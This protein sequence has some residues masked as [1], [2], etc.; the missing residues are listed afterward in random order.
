MLPGSAPEEEGDEEGASSRRPE[1]VGCRAAA[2]A[3]LDGAGPGRQVRVRAP[4]QRADGRRRRGRRAEAMRGAA[5]ARRTIGRSSGGGGFG[6]SG[7]P[8]GVGGQRRQ[9]RRECQP[10]RRAYP[11][12]CATLLAASRGRCHRWLAHA[13]RPNDASP[14]GGSG[15]WSS[16]SCS[17]PS[18]LSALVDAPLPSGTFTDDGQRQPDEEDAAAEGGGGEGGGGEGVGGAGGGAGDGPSVMRARVREV[19]AR[20]RMY[21]DLAQRMEPMVACL[22][23]CV[24]ALRARRLLR[25]QEE[26]LADGTLDGLAMEVEGL[27]EAEATAQQDLASG[28]PPGVAQHVLQRLQSDLEV[29]SIGEI[30]PRVRELTRAARL[31]L[32]LLKQLREALDL[33][34][35]ASVGMCVAA[36]ARVTRGHAELAGMVAHLKA[37]FQVHSNDA[38]LPAA[39]QLTISAAPRVPLPGF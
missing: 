24:T 39:R 14:E 27:V 30:S 36:A 6:G 18:A 2:T 16:Q 4:R 28:R 3:Y 1:A 8:P 7:Q 20:Q 34:T 17:S 10:E 37:L 35:S 19:L 9:R 33:D 38:I 31:S 11:N 26:V 23:R 21:V 32:S 12:G 13:H 25:S 15:E 22:E 29:S 5:A